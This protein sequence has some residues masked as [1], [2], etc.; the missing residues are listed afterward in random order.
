VQPVESV[1]LQV[2]RALAASVLAAVVDFA[3]LAVLREILGWG[4]QPAAVVG[5][6]AGGLLQY[7]LCSVWVFSSAPTSK[8]FGFVS[9]TVLSLGGLGITWAVMAVG[10]WFQL[11]YSAKIV[12]LG[13]SF[14][15]NFLSRKFLLFKP[16]GQRPAEATESAAASRETVD[17]VDLPEFASGLASALR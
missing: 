2:P 5:Y 12:A 7:V 17:D 15:W 4:P 14:C 1:L 10:E 13:L 16:S 6:L 9:F 3:T 11:V 8:T